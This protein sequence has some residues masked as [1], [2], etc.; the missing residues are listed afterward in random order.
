MMGVEAS[1]EE[2]MSA[3]TR[4]IDVDWDLAAILMGLLM[5]LG[6]LMFYEGVKWGLFEIYYQYTGSNDEE[7]E[8]AKKVE[9]INVVGYRAGTGKSIS[10]WTISTGSQ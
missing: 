7:N 5:I 2:P 9:R 4:T 6:G 3:T 1:P 10:Y 8:T